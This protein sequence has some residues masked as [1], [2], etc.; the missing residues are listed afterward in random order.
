MQHFEVK[1]TSAFLKCLDGGKDRTGIVV[2]RDRRPFAPLFNVGSEH[3]V[4]GHFQPLNARRENRFP[5][6][7][8]ID[9]IFE[10]GKSLHRPPKMFEFLVGQRQQSPDLKVHIN[11][12]IRRQVG[13]HIGFVRLVER[14]IGPERS[15]AT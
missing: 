1:R 6:D 12:R 4:D 15:G 11:G 10:V 3:F 5:S 7:A 8:Q 2:N 13:R 9:E 14:G